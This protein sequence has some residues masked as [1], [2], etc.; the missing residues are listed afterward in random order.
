MSYENTQFRDDRGCGGTEVHEQGD[1]APRAAE[2]RDPLPGLQSRI[3]RRIN[4]GAYMAD[5]WDGGGESDA[6]HYTGV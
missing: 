5:A 3:Y 6:T 4:D 2:N 1:N